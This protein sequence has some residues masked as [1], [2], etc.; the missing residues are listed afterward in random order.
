MSVLAFAVGVVVLAVSSF[1]FGAQ[2]GDRIMCDGTSKHCA[3]QT[4]GAQR[5]DKPS[6]P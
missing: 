6:P 3:I 4:D 2:Y 1:F 5:L